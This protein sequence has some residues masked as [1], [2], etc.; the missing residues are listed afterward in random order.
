MGDIPGSWPM[1]KALLECLQLSLLDAWPLLPPL[2][3]PWLLQSR[4]EDPRPCTLLSL[5]PF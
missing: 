3:W 4:H 5:M 2:T 1:T